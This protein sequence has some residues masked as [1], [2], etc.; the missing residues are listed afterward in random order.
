[1]IHKKTGN[2][3]AVS[4]CSATLNVRAR[5]V[6]SASKLTMLFP[7]P[8]NLNCERT[9]YATLVRVRRRLGG[10]AVP[11]AKRPSSRKQHHNRRSE[12][13]G[14]M[15]RKKLATAIHS[16]NFQRLL[17]ESPDANGNPSVAYLKIWRQWEQVARLIRKL[18][19]RSQSAD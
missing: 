6:I 13:V 17:P 11:G 10:L 9:A 3:R 19:K 5:F 18:L 4:Y 7:S 12:R 15:T 16:Q 2:L 1:L 8:R 14:R